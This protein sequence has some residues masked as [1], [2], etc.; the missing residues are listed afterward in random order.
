M[1][2]YL[3]EAVPSLPSVCQNVRLIRLELLWIALKIQSQQ[4][5][6]A[7][8]P[9]LPILVLIFQLSFQ[10]NSVWLILQV[11]PNYVLD[12]VFHWQVFPHDRTILLC[13]FFPV[14]V[15]IL[16]TV[17]RFFP[18]VFHVRPNVF[19]EI[20]FANHFHSP[21]E[22][23]P[24]LFSTYQKTLSSF[25][26]AA[27]D[28]LKSFPVFYGRCNSIQIFLFAFWKAHPKFL[29]L[30]ASPVKTDLIREL[31]LVDFLIVSLQFRQHPFS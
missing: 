3:H 14:V 25:L 16:L 29:Y 24:N 20:A 2:R 23:L 21:V 17:F 28:V 26:L 22:I 10:R 9:V 7:S 6:P 19:Q 12:F 8:L 18:N 15:A 11:V 31:I 13:Q 4:V 5:F 27:S 1:L 30:F